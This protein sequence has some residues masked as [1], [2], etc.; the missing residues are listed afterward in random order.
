MSS[1]TVNQQ[2]FP[3]CPIWYT[4]L[5]SQRRASTGLDKYEL[6]SPR[7]GGKYIVPSFFSKLCSEEQTEAVFNLN[8]KLVL[9]AWIA[10]ENLKGHIPDL[11]SMIGENQREAEDYF[12][13]KLPPIPNPGERANLLL[14]GLAKKS[15]FIGKE[16]NASIISSCPGNEMLYPSDGAEG[17]DFFYA[18]SYCDKEEE[19]KYLLDYLKKAG[20]IHFIGGSENFQVTVKGFEKAG[21]LPKNSNSKTVGITARGKQQKS[22]QRGYK[23]T[24]GICKAEKERPGLSGDFY[25]QG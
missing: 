22:S 15:N 16:F 8:E 9:S 24:Q 12:L 2:P 4:D 5:L 23:E 21:N 11:T 13:N 20:F 25:S 19:M 1:Q 18:L 14:E 10:R 7:A 3:Y 6:D 17:Y